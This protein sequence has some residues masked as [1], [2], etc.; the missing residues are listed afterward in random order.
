M[1]CPRCGT[2][3][4]E[5][6][7]SCRLCS[8]VLR[9]RPTEPSLASL[10]D[11]GEATHHSIP[12]A[13]PHM[14][15]AGSGAGGIGLG[16]EGYAYAGVGLALAI[17]IHFIPI[18]GYF[19]WFLSALFHETGHCVFAWAMGQPAFPA[20]S[21][22]GHAAAVHQGQSL[23]LTLAICAGLGF[24]AWNARG[25]RGCLLGLTT[26]AI[27]QPL[28]AFSGAKEVL[29]LLG[30]HLGELAFGAI[31]LWRAFT[32]GFTANKLER[33]L[34]GTLACHL[35]GENVLLCGGLLFSQAARL[36]YAGNGSFGLTNDFL[37]LTNDQLGVSLGT[38][39]FAMLVVSLLTVPLACW[40]GHRSLAHAGR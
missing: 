31:F 25:H 10:L 13:R 14:V 12:K 2:I 24:A 1:P 23:F 26:L 8:E 16:K 39:A 21:L 27:L 32:G 33:V 34:Y 29:F 35:I 28:L 11:P 38:V 5:D 6:S 4:G 7:Y 19:N 37:R 30:G 9:K 17:L 40:M 20:I 36:E 18:L 15:G 3:N 22:G